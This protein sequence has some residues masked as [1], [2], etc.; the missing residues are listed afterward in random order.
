VARL[1]RRPTPPGPITIL[2]D[3]LEALHLGAGE[4]STREIVG[5]CG[6]E[7]V[8]S[9]TTVHGVLVGPKVPKLGYLEL[10][11]EALRGNLAEFKP[12]WLEALLAERVG[13]GTL[14]EMPNAAPE[15][16]AILEQPGKA[17]ES[18]STDRAPKA[19]ESTRLT[20]DGLA[21]K[22][23]SDISTLAPTLSLGPQRTRRGSGT[24][25]S[26]PLRE[27]SPFLLG[28]FRANAWEFA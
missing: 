8:I 2:F 22:M 7:R 27:R 3:R 16:S 17:S 1:S 23:A 4:P 24:I 26:C 6:G 11:V 12:L 14:S 25:R 13:T 19:L 15:R 9:R 5:R 18:T 28:R 10:V 21:Q 20:T